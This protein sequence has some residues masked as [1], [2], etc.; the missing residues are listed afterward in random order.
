MAPGQRH[1]LVIEDDQDFIDTLGLVLRARRRSDARL[2]AMVESSLDAVAISDRHGTLKFVSPSGRQ[3]LGHDRARPT[4][5]RLAD[6]VHPEDLS[7]AR[8]A[9]AECAAVEGRAETLE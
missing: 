7:R 3:L 5:P 8:L 1:L 4:R 2:R 6:L 9:L